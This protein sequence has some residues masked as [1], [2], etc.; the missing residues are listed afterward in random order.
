MQFTYERCAENKILYIVGFSLL[1]ALS[2]AVAALTLR[3]TFSLLL[4]GRCLRR[5][6]AYYCDLFRPQAQYQPHK[7][8]CQ[9]FLLPFC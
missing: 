7:Q 4:Q 6:Y 3:P 2:A 5:Y 1:R 9:E 8:P